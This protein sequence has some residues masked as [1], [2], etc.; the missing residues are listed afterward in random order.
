[1]PGGIDLQALMKKAQAKG[2]KAHGAKP[3]AKPQAT[4]TKTPVTGV[5]TKTIPDDASTK[6]KSATTPKKTDAASDSADSDKIDPSLLAMP[7]RD[8]PEEAD[9]FPIAAEGELTADRILREFQSIDA[10][11]DGALSYLECRDRSQIDLATLRQFDVDNSGL[12]DTQEFESHMV[13]I[14]SS[15]GQPIERTL[16][17]RVDAFV[18]KRKSQL[19]DEKAKTQPSAVAEKMFEYYDNKLQTIVGASG[20]GKN[21][22]PRPP[23]LPP[24]SPRTPRLPAY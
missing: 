14:A 12:L 3:G 17:N 13:L 9:P 20:Q 10:N 2:Q 4:V 15:H 7:T 21:N 8:L 22:I 19:A 24:R 16:K 11:H 18:S 5:T 1:M 23:G 6:A